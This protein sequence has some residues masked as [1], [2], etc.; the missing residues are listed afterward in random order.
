MGDRLASG[1]Q[2]EDENGL[3]FQA[4]VALRRLR[5]ALRL[6]DD[7]NSNS[8]LPS[9]AAE[10]R[11]LAGECAPSRDLYVFLKET[12]A[13]PPRPILRIGARLASDH[14][15]RARAALGGVRY[16][17]FDQ[18]LARFAL[19]APAQAG[20]DLKSF[21]RTA[22]D[23]QYAKVRRRG[24]KLSNLKA[25]DV[26]R[27]RIAVKNLRYA[28][29]FLQPAFNSEVARPYIQETARL[30]D[31]LGVLHDRAVA[32]ETMSTIAAAARPSDKARRP[33]KRLARRLKTG[34][35]CDKRH[36]ERAWKSFRKAEPFWRV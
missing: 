29:D 17:A 15:T 24:R 6:L 30:Q 22:L 7:V 14:L 10:A 33:I 31:V 36:L 28:E 23:A 9:L 34:V 35:K 8:A 26:H 27:L 21:A 3:A 1:K 18:E 4:R 5:A 2:G 16:D 12:V 13:A 20:P 25:S 11:W 32:P 19:S